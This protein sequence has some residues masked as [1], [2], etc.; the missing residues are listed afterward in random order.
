MRINCYKN[1]DW[2]NENKDEIDKA[3]KKCIEVFV[4]YSFIDHTLKMLLFLIIFNMINKRKSTST[5]NNWK[6]F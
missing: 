5:I 3:I 1:A 2:P 6:E 4:F